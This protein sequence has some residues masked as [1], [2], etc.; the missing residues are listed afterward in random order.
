MAALAPGKVYA[1]TMD[2][3][4]SNNEDSRSGEFAKLARKFEY[5][6]GM[7]Y[8]WFF[9]AMTRASEDFEKMV[10]EEGR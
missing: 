1:L 6:Y 3:L 8:D 5:E 10:K 4:R 9:A 2:V 7:D